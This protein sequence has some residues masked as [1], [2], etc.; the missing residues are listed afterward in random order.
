MTHRI[1][2]I[3]NAI[4]LIGL[5]VISKT[6]NCQLNFSDPI[7]LRE[8]VPALNNPIFDLGDIND[9]GFKDV[10]IGSS[11]TF[12]T[13]GSIL[14]SIKS[15]D[16]I[17]FKNPLI[18][19]TKEDIKID[20]IFLR[21]LDSDGDLDI[22]YTNLEANLIA[23]F[24]NLGSLIFS[25]EKTIRP[26]GNGLFDV[27]IEDADNDQDIDIIC[28]Y[29]DDE[30]LVLF[31]NQNFPNR[32][33]NIQIIDGDLFQATALAIADINNDGLTDMVAGS[34]T[35]D[36]F[37]VYLGPQFGKT[38]IS[39]ENL[40]GLV[41]FVIGDI[42]HDD[43]PDITLL[44]EFSSIPNAYLQNN[45]D[46][47][48]QV[49]NLVFGRNED[50]HLFV[51][52]NEDGQSEVI[53]GANIP[54]IAYLGDR[55]G[56][57]DSVFNFNP[58]LSNPSIIQYVDMDN[59]GLEDVIMNAFFDDELG[60]YKHLP[61]HSFQFTS[62]LLAPGIK[63]NC[64]VFEDFN[65]DQRADILYAS[66]SAAN[67][68]PVLRIH[69]QD[70]Q[71]F[72]FLE[73]TEYGSSQFFI[74]EDVDKDGIKDIVSLSLENTIDI[75][76]RDNADEIF[77]LSSSLDSPELDFRLKIAIDDFNKDGW[78]DILA[79][80]FNSR[81]IF[82]FYNLNGIQFEAP[83]LLFQSENPISAY[84]LKDLNN[85]GNIDLLY[86]S[87]DRNNVSA[88]YGL[89]TQNP[90]SESITNVSQPKGIIAEYLNEDDILDI[91][92]YNVVRDNLPLDPD[93]DQL[94]VL[95][96]TSE[97]TYEDREL[98]Y[99]KLGNTNDMVVSD[100]DEDGDQDILLTDL[101]TGNTLLE[102][103]NGRFN[104]N[105]I[106]TP[107]PSTESLI[108]SDIDSDGDNDI[109]AI[110]SQ[111]YYLINL[112]DNF[113][114]TVVSYYDENSNG[115]FDPDERLLGDIEYRIEPASFHGYSSQEGIYNFSLSEI[116]NIISFIPDSIWQPT[117]LDH[118]EVIGQV[119]LDTIYFGYEPIVEFSKLEPDLSAPIT[120][121]NEISKFVSHV[122]N[123]GT[124]PSDG[125]LSIEVDS[126]T[127]VINQNQFN[128]QPDSIV[129]QQIFWSV[130]QL[131]PTE[132]Q[133]F[134]F[135]LKNPN[136]NYFGQTMS[137][138]TTV[139]SEEPQRDTSSYVLNARVTCAVDPNDKLVNPEGYSD[140]GYVVLD[141]EL[142]YTIRFQNTGNDTA[143]T[144]RIEDQ[145]RNGLDVSTFEFISAS[146][147][148][149]YGIDD[150][151][152]LTFLFENIMLPDSTTNEV[153]S[154]GFAKFRIKPNGN[155]RDN[156]WVRNKAEIYFDLN[157]PIITNE[158]SSRFVS[159]IPFDN[160]GDN[161]T[162]LEDC[163]DDNPDVN[164]DE[165]EIPY[166]GIDDDC[167]SDTKDD[168]L[169]NDGYNLDEDCDDTNDLINP[170]AEDIPNNG[171]DEDC[172]GLDLLS[173]THQ[174]SNS[175]VSI[176][177]NPSS[178]FIYIDFEQPINF[179]ISLYD[180]TGKI[181]LES[182]NSNILI[183]NGIENGIY[184]LEIREK[185][186]GQKVINKIIVQE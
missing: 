178:G 48:T 101:F 46:S 141:Q 134:E 25:E 117:D 179:E 102:Q 78:P 6:I 137:F 70:E 72:D 61:D 125:I 165:T 23:W 79:V 91:L 4:L 166:N 74:Y 123:K 39:D 51:D 163:D 77:T 86:C 104:A 146:H 124:L 153:E 89:S 22:I 139:I 28:T 186:S 8:D 18:I 82:V 159:V 98:I 131:Y 185:L 113:K 50:A 157:Q 14:I 55:L 88:I 11:S 112:S 59:D 103:D 116:P 129:G 143:F 68:D 84:N 19:I 114:Q 13:Y 95:Y 173:S 132:Q 83:Q 149:S 122:T 180:S 54:S 172:D 96:G 169:D 156:T 148:V 151:M 47:W 108:I 136:E 7:F 174:L 75:Y 182:N 1:S 42:N 126:L 120:R 24:E 73:F 110:G 177:P 33:F 76:K 164:P 115:A 130:N 152:K 41:D 167:S 3:L 158:V 66:R 52:I 107:S 106:T 9:D 60:L 142:E 57:I 85:D 65:G 49:E 37:N 31:R 27:E 45:I 12:Q 17:F 111:F 93:D 160:D 63:G 170:S 64:F 87:E 155:I 127:Q 21:D 32:D 105:V 40:T 145:I 20:D 67:S 154:H 97:Y 69:F 71:S 168:D 16:D 43:N 140:L 99:E 2:F 10:V 150:G 92:V 90:I 147:E 53:R 175:I 138:E 26:A 80:N 133:R 144:V 38:Q 183:L 29:R 35:R 15:E 162:V 62:S 118:V 119:Q 94:F 184:F 36:G 135:F 121:C 100:I 44:E 81:D 171:I 181:I 56:T 30:R 58:R 128:P 109:L 34:H 176:Y 161:F 5:V